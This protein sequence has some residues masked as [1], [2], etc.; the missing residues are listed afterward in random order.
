[1]LLRPVYSKL[2]FQTP[3]SLEVRHQLP[4][5]EGELV[6]DGVEFS[7][8]DLVEG[9]GH[10]VLHCQLLTV[11]VGVEPLHLWCSVAV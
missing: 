7:L 10:T 4:G 1:M 3:E 2:E 8:E 5:L 11:H 9:L 6:P